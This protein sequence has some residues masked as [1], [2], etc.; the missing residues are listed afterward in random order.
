MEAGKEST[1]QGRKRCDLFGRSGVEVVRRPAFFT[2]QLDSYCSD[3]PILSFSFPRCHRKKKTALYWI[4]AYCSFY[5]THFL[6][7]EMCYITS[8]KF[9]LENGRFMA[10]I[11][12]YIFSSKYRKEKNSSIENSSSWLCFLE[13]CCLW[14]ECSPVY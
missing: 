8:I 12:W 11:Y 13:K 6:M 2:L 1:L 10:Y 3:S 4:M 14:V 9:F 7:W 5:W